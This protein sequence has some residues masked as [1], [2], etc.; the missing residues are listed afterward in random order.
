MIDFKKLTERLR[1]ER[2]EKISRLTPDERLAWIDNYKRNRRN[3]L[4]MNKSYGE[5]QATDQIGH[6]FKKQISVY[7]SDYDSFAVIS[8]GWPVTYRLSD[9]LSRYPYQKPLCIDLSGRNHLNS[10]VNLAS[11]QIN[12]ALEIARE[13]AKQKGYKT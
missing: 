3:Y 9:L 13:V 4:Q 6:I 11:D 10:T 12:K 7:P 1:Q 8:F 5:V 2:K